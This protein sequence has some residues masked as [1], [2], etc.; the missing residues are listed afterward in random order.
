MK[1][2]RV[3]VILAGLPGLALAQVCTDIEDDAERLAC[4]DAKNEASSAVPEAP[5]AQQVPPAPT[6]TPVPEPDNDAGMTIA[7][8]APAGQQ[9]P[10]APTQTPLTEPDNNAATTIAAEAPED[11]GR[12]ESIDGPRE[13]VEA[14][15]VEIATGG[16][17]DYLRLDNGQVWREVGDSH[18][19]FKE[20][21]K[22]TIT[23]GFLSSY[24]LQ[25]EGYS[26]IV[27]VKRVR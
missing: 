25:M 14:T 17:I 19:R 11:F 2:S 24:D 16:E 23:E 10:P 6:Q 20:G 18:M 13:Y 21:R 9:V 3:F 12:R 1:S 8:E 4:Y 15:I 27:K 26:K 7:A 5:A 22:V